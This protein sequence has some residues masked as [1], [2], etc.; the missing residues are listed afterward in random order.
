M[1]ASG[2][3]AIGLVTA[4]KPETVTHRCAASFS[5]DG[6][7]REEGGP[8]TAFRIWSSGKVVTDH[9]VHEF[10]AESAKAILAD[11]RARKNKYSIDVDHMSLSE[12]APPA[13]HKAVGWFELAVRN[14]E[15]WAVNVE[16][17]DEVKADLT[18]SPPAWRYFSPAYETAKKS[19]EIVRLLN[20]ALTNNPATH[21]VTALATSAKKATKENVM[22]EYEKMTLAALMAA[23]E[24]EKDES[25]RA[26]MEKCVRAKFKAAFPDPDDKKDEKKEETKANGDDDKKDEPKKDSV[27]AAKSVDTDAIAAS[28]ADKAVVSFEAKRKEREEAAEKERILASL[29]AG[30]RKTYEDM[31]L[32]QVKRIVARH[33]SSV[34]DRFTGAANATPTQGGNVQRAAMPS[35]DKDELDRMMGISKKGPFVREEGTTLVFDPLSTSDDAKRML[36]SISGERSKGARSDS[37]ALQRVLANQK[38]AGQ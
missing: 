15:L 11:Q 36:A 29:P 10:T 35:E 2:P 8:P 3:L 25:K 9:G 1:G 6:V 28:I 30:D 17:T 38:G 20:L 16:W 27:A 32:E 13:N 4:R 5:D 37:E 21:E 23:M 18:K 19:G 31:S 26:D 22:D 33:H 34:L 7:E 12:S 24:D 14:G